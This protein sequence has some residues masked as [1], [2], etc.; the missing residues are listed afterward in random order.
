MTARK[1]FGG[2]WCLFLLSCGLSFSAEPATVTNPAPALS[3]T[4]DGVKVLFRGQAF[5]GA[6]TIRNTGKIPCSGALYL[7]FSSRDGFLRILDSRFSI[8]PGQTKR[9]DV[10]LPGFNFEGLGGTLE[11]LY[12]RLPLHDTV[13]DQKNL[14]V[15]P[16]PAP[17]SGQNVLVNG[18]F[19]LGSQF[20][21]SKLGYDDKTMMTKGWEGDGC[22]WPLQVNGWWRD[23]GSPEQVQ[24]PN[25]GRTGATC[26]RLEAS[27]GAVSVVSSLGQFVPV[28][29]YTLSAHV[30]TSGAKGALSL[31]LVT[32]MRQAKSGQAQ[33]RALVALPVNAKDWTRV[34]MTLKSLDVLQPFVRIHLASGSVEMDDVKLEL[35]SAA[36]AF[37]VR[38]A[39][40]LRLSFKGVSEAEMPKWISSDAAPRMVRVHNDSR[41]PIK[42]KVSLQFGPWNVPDLHTIATFDAADILPGESKT[43][44]FSTRNLRAD[45]YVAF[46]R[47][48]DGDV[49][50]MDGLWNFDPHAFVY[51]SMSN[52]LH[53][54]SVAR[55]VVVPR[56]EP[57]KIFG[58]G[59]T[60]QV[61]IGAQNPAS[62]LDLHRQMRQVGMACVRGGVDDDE[63]FMLAVAGGIPVY[64]QTTFDTVPPALNEFNNP[65]NPSRIDVYSK[66]GQ[67]HLQKTGE[68]C[69]R[70]LAANPL[71][72]GIQLANE[73]YWVNGGTPCPTKAADEHFRAWC[74]KR[75][76]SIEKVNKLWGTDY[77]VWADVDQVISVA[78]YKNLLAKT[79]DPLY[80]GGFFWGNS[81][82][83]EAV[84][85]LQRMPA[86]AMDW[87]RWRTETGVWSYKFFADAAK[88][89]DSRTLYSTDLPLANFFKQFF[90]PFVRAMDAA[91]LNVRYTSGYPNS[92]GVPHECMDSLELAES[93]AVEQGK[94][95]W[96]IE[97]Y[98]QPT[99]PAESAA[100]QNWGLI[101]HGMSV[102]MI[103]SWQPMSDK[104]NPQEILE[105]EKR[106]DRISNDPFDRACWYMIDADGAHLPAYDTYVR[107]LREVSR[108]HQ[109]YDGN[110]IRRHP[111]DIAYYVS[112]DSSEYDTLM[113]AATPWGAVGQRACFNLIYLL[114]LAGITANYVDDLTLPDRLEKYR[115]VIVPYAKVLSQEA[116]VKLARFAKAGGRVVLVGPAGQIDPWLRKYKN[117]GGPAWADLGWTAPGYK[118]EFF[119]YVFARHAMPVSSNEEY[120]TEK[121]GTKEEKRGEAA[122]QEKLFRGV[123]FGKPVKAKSICDNEG[124]T[125]GFRQAWGK[126]ELIAYGIYPDT[127]CGDPHVSPQM[128]G[129]MEQLIDLAGLQYSGRWKLLKAVNPEGIK[130]GTGAPVVDLVVRVKSLDEKF[131]FVLNQGG[132][133]EG[134]VEIPVG[135]GS[136]QAE[137]VIASNTAIT[138]QTKNGVWST[139]MTLT[140]LGCRVFRLH[141]TSFPSSDPAREIKIL[142]SKGGET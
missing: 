103:F 110:S 10:I 21:G 17:Q 131:V 121:A 106:A 129:W 109:K 134:L 71:V 120:S 108:Y 28:G 53:S 33:E 31:D 15:F 7:R 74:K 34:S 117:L 24:F 51:Y 72:A 87:L 63:T 95:F 124:Q 44:E 25:G 1:F 90:I 86:K 55:F 111:T 13:L 126:G 101:A 113:T 47:L 18:S 85:E 83:N 36:T 45:G 19:E 38:P 94:P 12:R 66:E 136:W 139:Q 4:L 133:G 79:K 89:H 48:Q 49:V 41:E 27:K 57:R 78:F 30:K 127:W 26:L 118:D 16:L 42:G 60:T 54:N 64:A 141:R 62:Y 142:V 68:E 32:G 82:P 76:G 97:V 65:C 11:L 115:V 99:W 138:S 98:H 67:K 56:V 43:F 46:L 107:S 122:P 104:G 132:Q 8:P 77:K 96:G 6:A 128:T 73:Q 123:D 119:P 137:D 52:M 116:A 135:D 114:R 2:L 88:K 37:N 112:N 40:F 125:I 58:I 5:A 20:C 70:F 102:P 14:T 29:T 35:G 3:G 61:K 81:W 69:G 93:I 91:M 75:Y 23:Q 105:W 50:V 84:K 92:F 100:L 39:E 22:W 9:Y 130:L 140:P 59:N 80:F